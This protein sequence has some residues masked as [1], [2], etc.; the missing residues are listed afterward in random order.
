MLMT[1]SRE[2]AEMIWIVDVGVMVVLLLNMLNIYMTIVTVLRKKLY[3]S[4]WYICGTVI[5]FPMLY[6]IGN[7]MW[8]PPTGALT[9]IDDTIY[10]WFYGHNVLDCGSPPACC[11]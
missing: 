1:Q 2:Y 9:G 5:W 11:Q 10:N 8:N 4:L 3:V 6:F 7:V